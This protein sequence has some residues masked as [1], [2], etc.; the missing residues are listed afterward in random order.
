MKRPSEWGRVPGAVRPPGRSSFLLP[1]AIALSPVEQRVGRP[2]PGFGL[3]HQGLFCGREAR[4]RRGILS[5]ICVVNVSEPVFGPTISF[6]LRTIQNHCRSPV[7]ARAG[8]PVQGRVTQEDRN[9][10]ASLACVLRNRLENLKKRNPCLS[11]RFVVLS[12]RSL[13]H[14]I[15]WV[16]LT[17]T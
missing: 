9:F 13:F 8:N 17:D 5:Q 14:S 3:V 11:L 10:A 6:G 12:S 4:P 1:Q 7:V 2:R 15:Y 16:K